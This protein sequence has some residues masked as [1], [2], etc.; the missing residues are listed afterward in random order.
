MSWK[1]YILILGSAATLLSFEQVVQACA[2]FYAYDSYPQFYGN[3]ITKYEPYAPFRFISPELYYNDYWAEN[4]SEIKD[5]V[6]KAVMVDEWRQYT[7]AAFTTADIEAVLFAPSEHFRTENSMKAW[8]GAQRRSNAFAAALGEKKYAALRRYLRLAKQCE[9]LALNR[10][11]D[12]GARAEL[13]A[14]DRAALQQQCLSAFGQEKDDF[15]KMKYAFQVMRLAFFGEEYRWVLEFF[16]KHFAH[17][18]EHSLAFTRIIGYKA[19]AHY[20]LG[21]KAKAA[22][23]YSLMFANSDAH[24]FE[25]LQSFEWAREE[26]DPESE[27]LVLDR[28]DEIL[29]MCANNKEKAVV[30]LM[31]G[32]RAYPEYAIEDIVKAYNFDPEVKGLDVLINREVNKLEAFYLSHK[33][34]RVNPLPAELARFRYGD[35]DWSDVYYVGHKHTDAHATKAIKDLIQFLDKLI[36]DKRE[37]GLWYVTKAYLASMMEQPDVMKEYLAK[38]KS[39][40]LSPRQESLYEVVQLLHT[41][42]AA[43][44]IT[45]QVEQSLLPQLQRLDRYALKHPL[46]SWQ[47]RDI[48][49]QLLAGR[50]MQ[51]GDTI[52]AVYAMAHASETNKERSSFYA[53]ADFQDAQGEALNRL[54]IAGLRKMQEFRESK[55]KTPFEDWLVSNTYYTFAVLKELE[56]TKHM[57]EFDFKTAAGVLEEHKINTGLYPNPFMPQINDYLELNASDTQRQY[58]KLSFSKRMAE[59]QDIIAKNPNDAGALYGYAVALYNISYYGKSGDMLLYNRFA[60]DRH[61]YYANPDED[62][63]LPRYLREYYRVHTAEQYFKKAAAAATDAELKAKALWGAAKCWTK[64]CPTD[65]AEGYYWNDER[66][67]Y[68]NALK[69]PHYKALDGLRQ[70]KYMKTVSGTCDYYADYI[71]KNG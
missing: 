67:Y 26:H 56:A 8:L 70:T 45:P 12:W 68:K 27:T 54:S 62:R 23:Y 7:K 44:K 24:K 20:R 46:A 4:T 11:E 37:P 2:D 31:K 41:I 13:P 42:Y 17:K 61:G 34:A 10:V 9:E 50:Y 48:M 5:S 19:G 69:N 63:M 14:T 15:L 66:D 25:A 58:T 33:L 57:R 30:M 43:N 16:D 21:E 6:N 51:Q 32:L 38:A 47:F 1:K 52:K 53:S 60:T 64:R 65:N 28:L 71:K 55:S 39:V 36:Q 49:N 22:Y 3:T 29:G 59:L 18:N 35:R 40:G